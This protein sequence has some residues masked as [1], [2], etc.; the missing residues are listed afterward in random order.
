MKTLTLEQ[1]IAREGSM[2]Q[3]ESGEAPHEDVGGSRVSV[4][5]GQRLSRLWKAYE[6]AFIAEGYPRARRVLEILW[7][8]D[9]DHRRVH[10]HL[11]VAELRPPGPPWKFI[12]MSNER[13]DRLFAYGDDDPAGLVDLDEPEEESA[14]YGDEFQASLDI[15]PG[16]AVADQL[17]EQLTRSRRG[18][19]RWRTR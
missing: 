10:D 12:S 1:F 19:E 3:A 8:H 11:D 16:E 4:P 15:R 6:A 2:L 14:R 18:K 5:S 17:E 13:I 9:T 7:R